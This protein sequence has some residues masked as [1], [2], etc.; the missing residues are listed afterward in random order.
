MGEL[1]KLFASARRLRKSKNAADGGRPLAGRN[2][3]LL[4]ATPAL[5]K[6]SNLHLAALE[7]GARVAQLRFGEPLPSQREDLRSLA[8]V[9]GRMYDAIDCATFD[10]CLIAEIERCASVPV[11]DGLDLDD[12]PVRALA[13]LMTLQDEQPPH[14]RKLQID[15]DGDATVSRGAA[16]VRAANQ[17]GYEVQLNAGGMAGPG[18]GI[19]RVDA[20]TSA[21]DWI[22]STEKGNLDPESRVENYRCLMQ[23]VLLR[24]LTR[25]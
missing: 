3:A 8:R 14:E 10:D 23:A 24:S 6:P 1:T 20:R 15:F 16:F 4:R 11:F 9:L 17:L 25:D 13:D 18:T 19:I 2:L 21:N 22:F 7:L 12:H 5:G